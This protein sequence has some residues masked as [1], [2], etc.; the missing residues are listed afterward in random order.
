MDTTKQPLPETLP[1]TAS[2]SVLAG[3]TT[4]NAYH[5]A[6]IPLDG[7]PTAE[8]VIPQFVIKLARPLDLDLVLFQAVEPLPPPAV[9]A[10]LLERAR[11][12]EARAAA[13]ERAIAE[14]EG[15]PPA[16]RA[17]AEEGASLALSLAQ[18][19][20]GR[21]R[22]VAAAVGA[23]LIASSPEE[24]LR[25]LDQAHKRGLGNLT[26]FVRPG[27]FE[28]LDGIEIVP[29]EQLLAASG[30][31]VTLEGHYYDPARGVLTFTGDTAEAVLL[32]LEAQRRRLLEEASALADQATR[33]AP[34]SPDPVLVGATHTTVAA[35]IASHFV[36]LSTAPRTCTQ[37]GRR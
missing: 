9:D 34:R 8:A 24:G 15:L 19:E 36:W 4:T 1:E 11:V 18:V 35:S 23:A 32:E 3:P 10:S 26:V 6:L 30:P 16:A 22:A 27:E 28:P 21:E 7:S 20:E 12:A 14:R 5:R 37:S 31:A 2:A 25:M 17:L 29:R 33:A 13:L